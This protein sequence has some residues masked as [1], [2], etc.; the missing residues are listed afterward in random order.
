[1]DINQIMDL[2]QSYFM[3]TF[4]KRVPV[5]FDRG[6]G[7]C[8]YSNDNIAYTDFFAGIAVNSLG[9]NNEALTTAITEQAKKLIHCSNYYYVEK[10]AE[11]AKELCGRTFANK[12]FFSN[13]GAEANEAAIKL[14]RAY[15]SKQGIKKYKVISLNSAFH[16]RT[17]ATLAATGTE[18]YQRPFLPLPEGFIKANFGHIEEIENLFNSD[19]EICAVIIEPI[20][21]EG[22]V[23]VHSNE[24]LQKLRKLC[25]AHN[26]L[27]IFDEVQ[28]GIC[29]TGSLYAYMDTG[30]I[31]DILTSAK[32]LGGGMPIGAC[33]ASDK[34]ASAFEPGDH[35]STYVGGPVS[36]AAALAV[37]TECDRL[38]LS[39]NAK[40]I[41]EYL[42]KELNKLKDICDDIKEI[43]G[44][45]LMIGI[46]FDK[47]NAVDIKNAFFKKHYLVG[48]A[49][50]NTLRLLPPL[51]ISKKDVDQFIKTLTE[52]L[53]GDL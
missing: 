51:I 1:M 53:E 8:L 9:Y 33:L 7:I 43:R 41:G 48:T 11:L 18:A 47:I 26:V 24:Y 30:V 13:S 49:G 22:G 20:M 21:G 35:G 46:Q 14:A 4:G 28:T 19:N 36:C 23:H 3:N 12:V 44:R 45:G 16:G 34:V 25:D 5:C 37:L 38:D 15:F 31:P 40:L 42:I 6:D 50:G 32:A 10:Q 27:L 17:L 52:I 29:R 39:G 2:D